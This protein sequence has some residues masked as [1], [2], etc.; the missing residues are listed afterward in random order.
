MC[1]ILG[2][3]PE[4]EEEEKI[5]IPPRFS[6]FG[7]EKRSAGNSALAAR[8]RSRGFIPGKGSLGGGIFHKST[9]WLCRGGKSR[10]G[11]RVGIAFSMRFFAGKN[12]EKQ[13]GF[14]CAAVL[15]IPD[16]ERSAG[17]R[18]KMGRIAGK[19]LANRWKIGKNRHLLERGGSH[20]QPAVPAGKKKNPFGATQCRNSRALWPGGKAPFSPCFSLGNVRPPLNRF[21]I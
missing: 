13:A 2:R 7:R 14:G 11:L 1:G 18:G 19:S 8:S 4:E 6:R 5:P 15:S 16:R 3:D 9:G 21:C 20:S 12:G 17:K 10:G